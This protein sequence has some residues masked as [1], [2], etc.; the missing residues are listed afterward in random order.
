MSDRIRVAD[1]VAVVQPASLVY[2]ASSASTCCWGELMLRAVPKSL[3]SADYVIERDGTRLGELKLSQST[4]TALLLKRT[5]VVALQLQGLDY[6]LS[7]EVASTSIP[8]LGKLKKAVLVREGREIA[9][10]VPSAGFHH[11]TVHWND[12]QIELK[13]RFWTWQKLVRLMESEKD[14]GS[15][16]R[17]FFSKRANL[18]LSDD[19]PTAV[20]A[21]ILW[22]ALWR[23]KSSAP[24]M[25]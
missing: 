6:E 8:F 13:G 9:W 16:Q 7:A 4:T 20:Q 11:F 14:V 25:D 21:F 2:G 5:P 10:A 18:Y 12:R 1:L 19:V 15:I 22:L 17:G 24:S 23:W 3:F